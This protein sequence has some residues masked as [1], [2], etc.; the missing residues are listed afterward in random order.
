[1]AGNSARWSLRA[2]L[3]GQ[4]MLAGLVPLLAVA[5]F[6]MVD[7]E[8]RVHEETRSRQHLLVRSIAGQVEIH[9]ASAERE[10][11]SLAAMIG[12]ESGPGANSRADRLLDAVVGNGALYEAI[13][14]LGPDQTVVGLGLPVDR[15]QAREDLRVVDVSRRAFVQDALSHGKIVWSPA[16]LSAVSG[17]LTVAVAMSFPGGLLI[18][19]IALP[20]LSGFLRQLRAES[21]TVSMVVDANGYLIAHPVHGMA[22]QQVS[23][24]GLDL[25]RAAFAEGVADGRAVLDGRP[26][27]GAAFR[28]A[29]TGWA[30]LVAQPEALAG[31]LTQSVRLALFGGLLLAV[32]LATLAAALAARAFARKFDLFAG[33]VAS[34]A[35][36]RYELHWPKTGVREFAMLAR[37]IQTTAAAIQQRENELQ[38]SQQRLLATIENTPNIAVQWFDRDGRVVYWNR[39]SETL[40]GVTAE[41]AVGC[42]LDELIYSHEEGEAFRSMLSGIAGDG[43]P[44]GPYEVSFRRADGSSGVVLC[45]TFQIPGD[46]GGPRFVSMD[47]DVT[48]QK[49]LT[50]EVERRERRLRAL[51]EQSPVAVIEWDL[52]FRVGE[53]NE[54]AERT[55]G[56]P[57]AA[58]IGQEAWF[59]VPEEFRPQAKGIMRDLLGQTGGS[60]SENWNLAAGGRRILC[61]WFNRPIVDEQGSLLS[62]VSLVRDVT[63][64]RQIEGEVREL[65]ANLEARVANRTEAL[66]RANGELQQALVSLQRAQSELVRSE[67]LAALGALVAGIAHELNTPIGNSLMAVTTYTEHSNS[68][69][70]L[71]QGGALRRSAL[72]QFVHDADTAAAII[73]RNLQKASELV[74]SF[75]QVAVDQTSAQRRDFFL[76]EVVDE[77]LLTLRPSYRR[78]PYEVLADVPSGIFLDSYPG[79]FGQVLTNLVNNALIHAFAGR[80]HGTIRISARLM[81]NAEVRLEVSDDGAGIP[82]GNLG[83]I[84]DPFFT[85]RLGQGGSGLGLHLVH[86]IATR[87]LGGRVGV[88]S[89]AGGSTFWLEIPLRAPENSGERLQ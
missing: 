13:Y 87:I 63:E 19:E 48:Q 83:R 9:L 60:Y 34:L 41:Q 8:P 80:E 29:S 54:A 47:V 72:D 10:L 66:E 1:M 52:D 89:S 21:Q 59:I 43:Q 86:N 14:L 3:F 77:V 4:L 22:G 32:A 16:F 65:N 88:T 49:R 2:I 23:L 70:T 50:T 79:P 62:V 55:F 78:T 75:K 31:R 67:K 6:V 58:A 12:A 5:W 61:Q 25:V 40:Y 33:N 69:R 76:D 46:E 11:S 85:T 17:R 81:G 44:V 71:L 51:I 73:L 56:Y 57:R 37:D 36:G 42:S 26:L 64:Q 82:E 84:F 24:S 74:S 18:G 15:R 30:V 7:V 45:T 35:Q 28:I 27:I 68:F 20:Q 39:S 38:T 53:W